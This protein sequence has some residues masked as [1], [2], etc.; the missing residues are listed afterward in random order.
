MICC[1][2]YSDTR[3]QLWP[4][5]ACVTRNFQSVCKTNNLIGQTSKDH[6]SK[7]SDWSNCTHCAPRLGEI[8]INFRFR[9]TILPFLKWW[10]CLVSLYLIII[11]DNYCTKMPIESEPRRS[12][13]HFDEVIDHNLVISPFDETRGSLVI[14][15]FIKV[16]T[17]TKILYLRTR[18]RTILG[19]FFWF[20]LTQRYD[21]TMGKWQILYLRTRYR[22]KLG[23]FFWFGP[24]Q[25]T[26]RRNLAN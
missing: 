5:K 4:N 17:D 9:A 7:Q 24:I 22:S 12:R 26:I 18:Y 13:R 1:T 10:P 19:W 23:W 15:Y 8:E 11:S 25:V 6:Q 20:W 3:Y 21:T 16:A 2:L 14:E